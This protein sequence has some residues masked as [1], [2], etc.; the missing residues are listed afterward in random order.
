MFDDFFIRALLAGIGIALV[1]GPLGCFVVWRKLAYFGDTLSHAA[2]L[3][4]GLAFYLG[5]NITITVFVV[6][7]II[8]IGLM[9]LQKRAYLSADSLLG[10][11]AHSA[12]ALGLVVLALL[13][14]VRI[15]LL[16]L[17]FGDILSTSRTDIIV[18]YIGGCI[19]L[20]VLVIIWRSLFAATVSHELA[21]AEGLRPDRADLI[22][23]LLLAGVIAMAIKIVGVL[24]ITALLIIPAAAARRFASGP[25]QMAI[26]AAFIGAMSVCAGLAGSLKWDTPSGPSIVIAAMAFFIV[27]ISPFSG[28]LAKKKPEPT[29]GGE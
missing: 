21:A 13:T 14:W 19:V 22:F 29:L 6:S 24:L 3:G 8:A 9:L 15:D 7:I 16:G 18:I 10:L 27:S 28:V 12:L 26:I 25:E 23:M 17:L 1:A 11:F 4:V 2:L 20:G 5:S